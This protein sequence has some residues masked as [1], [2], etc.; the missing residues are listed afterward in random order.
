MVENKTQNG[1]VGREEELSLLLAALR[2]GRH[3]LI[4]GPVGVGKT[5]LAQEAADRLDRGVVR[6]DGDE[7]Y[8]EDKLTGWFDPP[9]VIQSGYTEA[10]FQPGPLNRAL[11]AG[12]IL[13]INELN[14]LPEGVQN[15]LLPAMDEGLLELPRLEPVAAKAG[16]GI[17]A[18]QNPK[19]FVGTSLISEALRDRFELLVLDYQPFEEEER[20]VAAI[21]GLDDPELIKQ[22]VFLARSTRTHPLIKRGASVRAA[23]SVALIGSELDGEN[24]LDRAAR[25]ALP[26]RIEFKDELE[27]DPKESFE[28]FLTDVKKKTRVRL[29]GGD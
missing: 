24:R 1:L 21:T 20:I 10:A 6:I 14:R 19:E 15:V 8:T 17:V 18:T 27:T 16:F 22:A 29:R 3:V 28:A 23:A 5:R 25:L 13:F 4:E 11:E 12:S 26:T 9:A 7:R 2:A